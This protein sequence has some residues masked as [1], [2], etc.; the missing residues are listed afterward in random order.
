MSIAGGLHKAIIRAEQAGCE[1]LQIFLHNQRQWKVPV[2]SKDMVEAFHATRQ[3]SSIHGIVAHASYLINLAGP[4]PVITRK[5]IEVLIAEL[6]MAQTLDLLG[7]I[8]HIGSRKHLTPAEGFKRAVRS[9]NSVLTSIPE[10][11]PYIFLE[12]SAGQGQTLASTVEEWGRLRDA[13]REP[14]KIRFCLDT[15]HAFVSGYPIHE[16]HGYTQFISKLEKLN[17][18]PYI[19]VIHANDAKQPHGSRRDRHEHI[20]EGYIGP[21]LFQTLLKDPVFQ[22]TWFI[23]ETPKDREGKYDKINLSRL[24]RYRDSQ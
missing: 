5:S 23:I 16:P 19:L 4:D 10:G 6:E 1:V 22:H 11:P 15:C 14:E 17:I 18:L 7:V 21:W 12:N 2:L 20:G 8:L 3:E 13:V 24:R 9:L